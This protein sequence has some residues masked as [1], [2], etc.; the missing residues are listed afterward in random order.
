MGNH[1]TYKWKDLEEYTKE[2]LINIIDE[3]S[4]DRLRLLNTHTREMDF[5]CGKFYF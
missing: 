1:W 3:M 2:E 5:L 4:Y